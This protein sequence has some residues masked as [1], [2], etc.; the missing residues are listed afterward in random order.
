M[1]TVYWVEAAVGAHWDTGYYLPKLSHRLLQLFTKDSSR[2]RRVDRP[3]G[4]MIVNALRMMGL[5]LSL[6][7]CMDTRNDISA[8]RIKDKLFESTFAYRK[9][10]YSWVGRFETSEYIIFYLIQQ[11]VLCGPAGASELGCSSGIANPTRMPSRACLACWRALNIDQTGGADKMRRNQRK[12]R[13]KSKLQKRTQ[14][15]AKKWV[16]VL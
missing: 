3:V 14:K 7:P 4:V 11:Q 12:R 2:K 15:Y 6:Q 5:N 9:Y 13:K 10:R 16:G 1:Y 8:L